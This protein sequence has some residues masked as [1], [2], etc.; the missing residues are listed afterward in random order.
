MRTYS[1]INFGKY[2]G[3]TVHEVLEENPQYIKWC[4]ENTNTYP[5]IEVIDFLKNKNMDV[6]VKCKK[7]I[8]KDLK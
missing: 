5:S 2:K 1:K 8:K 3:K 7:N 4:I 6:I